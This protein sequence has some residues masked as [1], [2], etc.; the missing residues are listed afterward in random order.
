M[1]TWH[2][3]ADSNFKLKS[4][5]G[6]NKQKFNK[7]K[8]LDTS[9]KGLHCFICNGTDHTFLTCKYD[10]SRN[11][12]GRRDPSKCQGCGS[13]KHRTKDCTDRAFLARLKENRALM[14][15]L[16]PDGRQSRAPYQSKFDKE[17]AARKNAEEQLVQ[18]QA[19]LAKMTSSLTVPDEEMHPCDDTEGVE[20]HKGEN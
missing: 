19:K 11:E 18:L 20:E 17:A 9:K 16:N 12:Y 3:R 14:S 8:E 13:A 6:G 5:D 15:G 1:R 4:V 7:Q 10:K 2:A